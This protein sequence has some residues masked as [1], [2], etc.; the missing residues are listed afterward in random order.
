M[1]NIKHKI[2]DIF[3][4]DDKRQ[5]KWHVLDDYFITS[6][7]V[8]NIVAMMLE[9][10]ESHYETYKTYYQIFDIFSIAVFSVEYMIRIWIAD[11]VYPEL[12]KLK[13][14]FKYIFSF[15]GIIDLLAIL[16]F[17]LPMFIKVDLRF[18][19]I[20]RLMRIFRVFKLVR[21]LGSI[22]LLLTAIKERKD[23]LLITLF[24]S[25]LM[26]LVSA[27]LMYEI[28]H[29]L[30]P[31][32]FSNVFEAIWWAV[33]TLTTIGYG[34]VYPI[35]GWGQ[36]LAAITA[37][38]GIGLVAIPTGIISIGFLEQIQNK[39]ASENSDKKELYTYCPHCGKK[40]QN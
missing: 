21:F 5:S 24:G 34:D 15:F 6:L 31:D 37:L 4:Y 13:S 10:I 2:A 23:E 14:R 33:A 35:S 16:P 8:L 40:L 22:Q 17:Y 38:F 12:G 19:R 9:S 28:E 30:Q 3:I 1:S 36:F 20:L 27:S 18:M 32:K 25:A 26:L 7:I 39:K 11:E 29:E